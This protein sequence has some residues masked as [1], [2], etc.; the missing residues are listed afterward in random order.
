MRI[1]Q[2]KPEFWRDEKL[3]DLGDSERL[4]YIGLWMCADDAG[5]FRTNVREIG[6][7]LFPYEDRATREDRIFHVIDRLSDMER[8]VSE[9]CGRH[10]RLPYLP[11]HQRMSSP[12]KRVYTHEREHRATCISPQTPAETR[13]EP[14][15][16]HDAPTRNVTERNGKERNGTERKGTGG[17]GGGYD[18]QE[19][20]LVRRN[21]G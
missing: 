21:D 6:A 9:P 7:D 3:A 14:L 18:V 1:R 11:R 4:I 12:D 13:G 2:V 15:T 20:K 19:G 8:I 17:Y 10:A 16:L 5:W